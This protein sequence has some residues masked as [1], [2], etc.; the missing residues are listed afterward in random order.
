MDGQIGGTGE[1]YSTPQLL[2]GFFGLGS[3]SSITQEYET[4]REKPLK[5]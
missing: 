5:V 3:P 4:K 1:N 2:E